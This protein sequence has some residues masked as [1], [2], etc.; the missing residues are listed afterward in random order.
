MA[1]CIYKKRGSGSVTDPSSVGMTGGEEQGKNQ[2]K[3]QKEKVARRPTKKPFPREAGSWEQEVHAVISERLGF[4]T[5]PSFVG[6]TGGEEPS[7][8]ARGKRKKQKVGR[9]QPTKQ[10]PSAGS[11]K[12]GAGRAFGYR[13][14]ANRQQPPARSQP[15]KGSRSQ[16][17]PCEEAAADE[18]IPK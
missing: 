14:P 15:P 2:G 6:M 7:A 3:S 8:K 4:V 9:R 12:L 13:G 11:G 10:S 5:D 16:R 18:A 1:L 17:R